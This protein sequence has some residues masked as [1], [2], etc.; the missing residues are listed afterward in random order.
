R[1]VAFIVAHKEKTYHQLGVSLCKLWVA[2]FYLP[3]KFLFIG[4]FIVPQINILCNLLCVAKENSTFDKS[5]F[6]IY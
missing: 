3:S 6:I 5:S 1:C 4:E 2:F